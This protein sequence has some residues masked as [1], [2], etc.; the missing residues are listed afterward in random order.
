M[1]SQ[2]TPAL[3]SETARHALCAASHTSSARISSDGKGKGRGGRGPTFA[4]DG[5][6]SRRPRR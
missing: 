6:L 1:P 3:E 4:C 2:S 5:W